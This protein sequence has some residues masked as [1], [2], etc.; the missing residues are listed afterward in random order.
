M[1]TLAESPERGRVVPELEDP[2]VHELFVGRYRVLYEIHPREV[3]VMRVIHG[4]RDLLLALGKRRHDE[5]ERE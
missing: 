4:N 3:W 5:S 1:R 2:E